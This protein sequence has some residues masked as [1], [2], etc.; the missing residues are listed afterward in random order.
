MK[1]PLS[2]IPAEEG[3]WVRLDDRM[4]TMEKVVLL[5]ILVIVIVV[6]LVLL[7]GLTPNIDT[8]HLQNDIR[9]CCSIYRARGCP[10][11]GLGSII[12]PN[13]NSLEYLINEIGMSTGQLYSFCS[14]N[15]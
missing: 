9:N 12:C 3:V 1:T 11:V 13:D 6:A 4:L 7:F 2:G 8:L 10:D 15:M 14:C 5:V